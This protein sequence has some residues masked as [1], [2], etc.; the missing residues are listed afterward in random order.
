MPNQPTSDFIAVMTFIASLMF[1]NEVA[2]IVG[3]YVTIIAAASI[4]ASFA[5]AKRQVGTRAEGRLFFVRTV[6]VALM[7]TVVL[8]QI[9][10]AHYPA[11]NERVSL[12]PIAMALGFGGDDVPR[13]LGRLFTKLLGV[14]DFI[15]KGPP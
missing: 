11:L 12:I 4:G 8:S 13:L 1:S 3:P 10:H 7:F 6:S 5:L 9:V 2:A 14:F 15:K